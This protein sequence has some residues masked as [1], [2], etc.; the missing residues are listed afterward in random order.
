MAGLLRVYQRVVDVGGGH[1]GVQL[2]AR[3]K[4]VRGGQTVVG[5]VEHVDHS[6]VVTVRA[7]WVEHDLSL[8]L[9]VTR[10]HPLRKLHVRVQL[11]KHL[12]LGVLVHVGWSDAGA[13]HVVDRSD[14]VSVL[15]LVANQH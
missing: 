3:V 15:S 5:L 1:R 9:N 13:T 8:V 10:R 7:H 12:L 11:S 6:R 4:L 14:H 2:A